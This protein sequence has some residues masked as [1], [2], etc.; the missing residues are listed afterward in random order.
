MS[1]VPVRV[2][3]SSA[4]RRAVDR[5]PKESDKPGIRDSFTQPNHRGFPGHIVGGGLAAGLPDPSVG[6][7]G[8]V[9]IRAHVEML[10]EILKLLWSHIDVGVFPEV[11]PH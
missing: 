8:P 6:E 10:G 7:M 2:V 5:V 1:R 4:T 3:A 9:P 11:S